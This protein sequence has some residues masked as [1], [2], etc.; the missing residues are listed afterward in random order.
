MKRLIL[1]LVLLILYMICSS[2][3]KTAEYFD[4]D[5]MLPQKIYCYWDNYNDNKI[6]QCHFRNWIKNIP[7]GWQVILLDKKNVH[8]HVSKDFMNKYSNLPAFR[9]ADF[10]RLYLLLNNG[11]VWFDLS[12]FIINGSFLDIYRDEMLANKYDICLYEFSARSIK[13]NHIYIPYYENWFLMAPKGSIFIRDLY[14]EFNKAY[15]MDFLQYKNKILR[16]SNLDMTHT[17]GYDDKTYLM[18]H[19]IIQTLILKNKYKINHKFAEESMFKLQ[20]DNKWINKN[21]INDILTRTNWTN[22]YA[23]KLIRGNMLNIN[24]PDLYIQKIDSL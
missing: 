16:P 2:F 23:V 10:L 8:Q 24:N 9:F 21:I 11:G 6:I 18:Q 4:A 14:N 3:N 15:D 20:Q 1:I 22:I 7:T 17:L 5:Y 13:E 12:S 19:V